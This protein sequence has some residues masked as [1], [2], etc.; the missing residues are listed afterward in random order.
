MNIRDAAARSGLNPKTIRFYEEI[1]LVGP[2]RG[3]NG[4]RR[5][6]EQDARRLAF[7]GRARSLGFSVEN[8][9]RLLSLWSDRQRASADVKALAE[10]HLA[11]IDR[12]IAGLQGLRAT[13]AHLVTH[14]LGDERPD[15]PI[16]DELA[17]AE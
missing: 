8:C 5:F 4:Y 9:R 6:S 2:G 14:C 1:G 13:L 12:K 7:I 15:C 17:A 11:E 16:L 3:E 10:A